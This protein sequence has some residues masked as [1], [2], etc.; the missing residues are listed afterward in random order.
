M[1]LLQASEASGLI[2]VADRQTAGR[3]RNARVWQSPPSGNLHASLGLILDA[4]PTVLP[5]LSLVAGLA[6]HDAVSALAPGLG[7]RLKLKWPNDVLLD[8]AKLAGVLV[9][10]SLR[11]DAGA[12]VVIGVGLNLA[13]HPTDLGRPATSLAAAGLAVGGED[14]VAA[15][16]RALGARLRRWC[17]GLGL[18]GIRQAFLQR[19]EGVGAAISVDL[20]PRSVAGVWIGLAED[21]GLMVKT[22]DGAVAHVSFGDVEFAR[23]R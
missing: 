21:G 13:W 16:S 17:G 7:D 18:P 23:A 11:L 4:P 19:A 12:L 6:V 1:R 10:S 15:L 9:E 3:G 2:V 20:G 8:G 5:Q 14:A 22:T